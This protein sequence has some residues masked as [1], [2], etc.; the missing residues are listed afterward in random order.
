VHNNISNNK[1]PFLRIAR[2]TS[3]EFSE[4]RQ[5]EIALAESEK[6]YRT[7]F[8]DSPVPLWEEDC[9]EVR[10]YISYLKSKG[11]GEFKQY[12]ENHPGD[13]YKCLCMIKIVEV[14]NAALQLFKAKNRHDLIDSIGKTYTDNYLQCFIQNLTCVAEGQCSLEYETERK[15]LE[16]E[17]IYIGVKWSVAP[18]FERTHQKILVN[19]VD[20][21]GKRAAELEERKLEQQ[22][23][24]VQSMDAIGTLAGGIAHDFNNILSVIIGNTELAIREI[25]AECKSETRMKRVLEA[26]ERASDLVKQI[27]TFSR[28]NSLDLKRAGNSCEK[29]RVSIGNVPTGNEYILVVDDEPDMAL[30]YRE[31]LEGVG[32]RVDTYVNSEDALNTFSRNPRSYDLVITDQTMPKRSGLQLSEEIAAINPDVKII[33]CSGFGHSSHRENPGRGK[34]DRYSNIKAYYKKPMR[35]EEFGRLVRCVLDEN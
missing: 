24:Q 30:I 29:D 19:M 6:R 26:A 32:Y 3:L 7:L 9:S 35:L 12:F 2:E 10:A 11:I 34:K 1:I 33:V 4:A 13:V 5:T 23:L 18:G 31:I 17:K 28:E 22:L 14:N 20:L 8:E 25:P 16:G 27:L 21:T 15:N